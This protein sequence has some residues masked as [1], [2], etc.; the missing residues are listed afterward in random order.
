MILSAAVEVAPVTQLSLFVFASQHPGFSD[1]N[2]HIFALGY[3]NT[4][5]RHVISYQNDWAQVNLLSRTDSLLELG[6]ET[7][8]IDQLTV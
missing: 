1:L 5:F 4:I 2:S 7:E 6:F 8:H 3:I